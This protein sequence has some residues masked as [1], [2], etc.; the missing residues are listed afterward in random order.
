MSFKTVVNTGGRALQGHAL[1]RPGAFHKGYMARSWNWLPSAKEWAHLWDVNNNRMSLLQT[2][3]KPGTFY[4]GRSGHSESNQP[5]FSQLVTGRTR[6]DRR[7]PGLRSVLHRAACLLLLEVHSPGG[8]HSHPSRGEQV[9]QGSPR[10]DA[11]LPKF[12]LAP[13]KH[14]DFKDSP[15][16][17]IW[18]VFSLSHS[19]IL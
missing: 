13:L 4:P 3:S 11:I 9:F 15:E 14:G 18:G 19:S 7:P 2:R 17:N 16:K 1:Q 12:L 10:L 5:W 8:L 6:A